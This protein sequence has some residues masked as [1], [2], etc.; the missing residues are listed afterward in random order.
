M[1]REF[2]IDSPDA[3]ERRLA[4]IVSDIHARARALIAAEI[5]RSWPNFD[6]KGL[7]R[8]IIRLIDDSDLEEELVALVG[9][10]GNSWRKQLEDLIGVKIESQDIPADDWI[11]EVMLTVKRETAGAVK[12]DDLRVD[13]ILSLLDIGQ[14]ASK[15]GTSAQEAGSRF[16]GRARRMA[17]VASNRAKQ[18]VYRLGSRANRTVQTIAGIKEYTWRTRRDGRVR[19]THARLDGTRQRWDRP[20]II[21]A[22]GRRGHP[23]DDYNCR[24]IALPVL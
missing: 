18:A 20:P 23:G 1:P 10:V 17:Q 11:S 13:G 7:Q 19:P 9:K 15:V 8:K 12:V 21:S 24:C 6:R 5:K 4:R 16:L 3:L 14:A 2:P 22:D